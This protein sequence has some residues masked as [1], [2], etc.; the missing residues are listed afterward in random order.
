MMNTSRVFMLASD[1]RWQWAEWCAGHD[2]DTRRISEVKTLVLDAFLQAREQSD[3]VRQYGALLLDNQYAAD[4]I[5]EAMRRGIPVGA[6][7]EK[8]GVFPLQWEREPF[9]AMSRGNSFVKVLVRYRPEWPDT[10]REHQWAKLLD[11]QAWCL[12]QNIPLLVEIII[13][14]AGE[15]EHDFEHHG[16]PMMLAGLIREAY[17]RGLVPAVWKIEGTAN[18]GGAV[19]IDAAIR[20]RSGPRQLILGKGAG[21]EAI[22]SWFDAA[23]GLPSTAGFAIG[24][25]VFME[26]GAAYLKGELS[27]TRAAAQ[28]AERYLGFVNGWCA[29]ERVRV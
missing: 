6:P 5:S 19:A 26:P 4:A 10:Q 16:R 7:V 15:D 22:A 13:M 12:G 9:H 17:A 8:A 25:S 14:R 28:I 27:G 18:R 29:R 23:A 3:D 11:L 2:V 20:E 24:R 21:P 1:H